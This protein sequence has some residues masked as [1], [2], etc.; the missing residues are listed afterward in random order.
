MAEQNYKIF[1]NQHTIVLTNNNQFA[2]NKE[3]DNFRSNS[4]DKVL[5]QL[6]S[7][8][9]EGKKYLVFKSEHPGELFKRLRK[10]FKLIKAAGGVVFNEDG[11]LLL[12]K[13]LGLW[14]LPKGKL[15]PGEDQ[16]LAALREVHEECGLNFLGILGKVANTYHVY[17]LK[18]RW[19]LKKS[20][21]Y[22]MAAWG[23]VSVTPQLEEGITEVCWVDKAFIK[24]K[25]FD[26][27]DSL[28]DL[29]DAIEFPK[30]HKH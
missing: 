11:Q 4:L 12:I 27:Y 6:T 25:G 20:A 21:W 23:D 24:A 29:F 13:R 14:D 9:F 2:N 30:K 18:G 16:R 26:T 15:E 22:R 19:I 3:C 17:H 8:T 28:R 1:I 7:G 5:Q 10:H